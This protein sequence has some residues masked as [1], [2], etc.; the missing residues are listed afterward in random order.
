VRGL[1]QVN[2]H[3]IAAAYPILDRRGELLATR[4]VANAS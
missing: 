4:R 1:K 2:G 3:I